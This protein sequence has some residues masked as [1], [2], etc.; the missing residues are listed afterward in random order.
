MNRIVKIRRQFLQK[1][2]LSP[3]E[4]EKFILGSIT[5]KK[6]SA[7]TKMIDHYNKQ[8]ET[9]IFQGFI[10][11]DSQTKP[12]FFDDK[13]FSWKIIIVAEKEMTEQEFE[14]FYKKELG[15][16]DEIFKKMDGVFEKVDQEL[17]N[18]FKAFDDYVK[19]VMNNAFQEIDKALDMFNNLYSD[20][21]EKV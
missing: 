5:Q 13:Y 18:I 19:P 7:Y 15:K 10:I 2:S 1:I 11:N 3:E 17:N 14:K 8:K 16:Y 9:L 20:K 6:T 4:K 21:K 12:P